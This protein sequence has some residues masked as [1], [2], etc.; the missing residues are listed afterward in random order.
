MS[1]PQVTALDEIENLPGKATHILNKDVRHPELG[2]V[3]M[4]T[5]LRKT[6]TNTYELRGGKGRGKMIKVGPEH[7]KS[8]NLEEG[9]ASAPKTARE[10][11][12]AAAAEPH[13]KITHKDVLVK[14]GAIKEEELDEAMTNMPPINPKDPTA[15]RIYHRDKKTGKEHATDLF[16]SQS[17]AQHER[18][19]KRGGHKVVARALMYG[20]KEGDRV[21]VKEETSL[22]EGLIS[23]ADFMDKVYMHRKA[24][25]DVVDHKYDAKKQTASYTVVDREG[26]GRKVTHTNTGTKVHDLGPMSGTDDESE[27]TVQNQPEK[28][29]RGRPRGSKSGA[30][31]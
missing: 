22:K 3:G 30:R 25:N 27:K 15:V 17:A 4:G 20:Q 24:G 9:D 29:G 14:R 16:S 19:L 26:Q 8:I 2:I 13:D 18:E 5:A 10:K 31:H 21:P 1:Q 11:D 6:G 12:L 28:R 23:Y 7:T